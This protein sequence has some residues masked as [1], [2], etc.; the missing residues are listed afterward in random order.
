MTSMAEQ[1]QKKKQATKQSSKSGKDTKAQ[2]KNAKNK[3]P[4]VFQRFISYLKNVRQ[5][6]KRTTWPSRDEVWRMSLIVVGALLFF[7]VLIFAV[8]QL[9]TFLLGL[10]AHVASPADAAD[11]ATSALSMTTRL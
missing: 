7:G 2:S 9:M 5:E 3:K 10:Y 1:V 4:N 8:D 11:A 6:I